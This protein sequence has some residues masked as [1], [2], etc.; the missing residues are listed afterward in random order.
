MFKHIEVIEN[1]LTSQDQTVNIDY[2]IPVI[3]AWE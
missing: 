1:R 2:S 3:D